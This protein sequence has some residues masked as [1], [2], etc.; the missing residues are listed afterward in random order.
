MLN[1]IIIIILFLKNSIIIFLNSTVK[2]FFNC[3]MKHIFLLPQT[4]EQFDTFNLKPIFQPTNS[5]CRFNF[6]Y[7]GVG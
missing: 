2:F 5:K 1:L 6:R 4:C 7:K 3:N